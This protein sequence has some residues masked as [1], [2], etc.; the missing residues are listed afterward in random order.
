[1]Q[2]QALACGF[3]P[4]PACGPAGAPHL[5]RAPQALSLP[6]AA[7]PGTSLQSSTPGGDPP[8]CL[9]SE[10]N[11]GHTGGLAFP[12]VGVG[13]AAPPAHIPSQMHV[14]R[15][16]LGPPRWSPTVEVGAG[17]GPSAL[18]APARTP[19]AAHPLLGPP[20]PRKRAAPRSQEGRPGS[21][22]RPCHAA[23]P[24]PRQLLSSR[25]APAGG[26]L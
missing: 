1:M 19:G 21:P 3:L 8:P 20:F 12:P 11:W 7:P 22:P 14:F 23:G 6:P 4:P 2:S 26:C 10:Q 25:R 13:A 9:Q 16:G 5:S 18:P 17:R 15:K 24:A